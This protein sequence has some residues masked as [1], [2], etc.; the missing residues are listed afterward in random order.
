[1]RDL[2]YVTGMRDSKGE[3]YFDMQDNVLRVRLGLTKPPKDSG[4]HDNVSS[5]LPLSSYSI[6]SIVG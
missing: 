2:Y 6:W 1:M 5:P 3:E 4:V